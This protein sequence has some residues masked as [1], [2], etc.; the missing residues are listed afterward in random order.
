M[1]RRKRI[2]RIHQ[3]TSPQLS[4]SNP[5]DLMVLPTLQQSRPES[6]LRR[7]VGRARSDPS[8]V[9]VPRE[10]GVDAPV[11]PHVGVRQGVARDA[12]AKAHVIKFGLMIAQTGFD[13]AQTVAKSECS[14][15]PRFWGPRL[16]SSKSSRPNHR[17]TSRQAPL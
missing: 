1:I 15:N 10:V 6:A 13:I 9:R 12:A 17:L 11:A 2:A 14:A 16:S 8:P 4:G 3:L 5:R 7:M